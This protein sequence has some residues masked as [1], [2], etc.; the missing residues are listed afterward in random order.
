[1]P[2]SSLEFLTPKHIQVE[3]LNALP[4]IMKKYRYIEPDHDWNPIEVVMTE[5]EIIKFYFNYW[6]TEMKKRGKEEYISHE[7]CID[8]FCVVH[9][10]TEV[11]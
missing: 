1:M 8:D 10:A 3:Q 7:N 4:K 5:E 2:H 9:W 11:I 6:S